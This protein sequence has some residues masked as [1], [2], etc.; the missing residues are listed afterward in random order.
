MT[1]K[2]FQA[3]NL[4]ESLHDEGIKGTNRV[5]YIRDYGFNLGLPIVKDKAWFW[6]AYGVQDIKS[7]IITGARDD[8][9]MTNYTGKLNLQVIPQNRLYIVRRIIYYG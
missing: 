5:E 1:D 4:T 2:T 6:M 7:F 8:T 3:D 9:L